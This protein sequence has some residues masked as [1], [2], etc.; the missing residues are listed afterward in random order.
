MI[1][2]ANLYFF[3]LRGREVDLWGEAKSGLEAVENRSGQTDPKNWSTQLANDGKMEIMT[4][5][6][7]FS[8]LKKLAN[9]RSHV[10]RVGQFETPFEIIFREPPNPD[11]PKKWWHHFIGNKYKRNNVICIMCDGEFYILKDPRSLKFTRYAQIWTLGKN[12]ETTEGRLVKD[13]L[14]SAEQSQE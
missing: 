13:E 8:Y 11:T 6:D 1:P 12:D 14:I 3:F 5:E 10:S 9:I 2:L 7:M 4:I